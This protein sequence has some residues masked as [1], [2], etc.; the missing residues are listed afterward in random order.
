M[1]RMGRKQRLLLGWKG[2]LLLV[3]LLSLV[4]GLLTEVGARVIFAARTGPRTLFY[5]TRFH[6]PEIR[7]PLADTVMLHKNQ[8]AGYTKYFPNEE[9]L[10]Y[11]PDTREQFRVTINNH[12]FRGRDFQVE[13]QTGT[14]RVVTLGASSTLGYHNRDDET[15]PHLLEEYLNRAAHGQGFQVINLAVPHLSSWEI[16]ALFRTEGLPLQPDVVTFYEGI[17]DAGQVD[18]EINLG[19]L[20]EHEAMLRERAAIVSTLAAV[21]RALTHRSVLFALVDSFLKGKRGWTYS[22]KD[23]ERHVVGKRERFLENVSAIHELCKEK[24]IVFIVMKQ[25]ARSMLI[26]ELKGLTYETEA[27]FVRNQLDAN[28]GVQIEA[29]AFLTHKTLMDGLEEWARSNAVPM[30]DAISLLNEDRD[31]LWTWVHLRP[32]GNEMIAR[33]LSAEILGQL[34]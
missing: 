5:G 23:Y 1:E 18:I 3:I 21:Y 7:K 8:V 28:K 22:K 24:G 19:K 32:R 31:V 16:L 27:E 9:K 2:K 12:G 11:D 15:Y 25:Q 33:A 20:S 6:R 4:T 29:L 34:E 30:V 14:I 26:D 10:D 13:K 17:N